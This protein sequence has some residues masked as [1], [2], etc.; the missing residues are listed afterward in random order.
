[1]PQDTVF[2]QAQF[3]SHLDT[4]YKNQIIDDTYPQ[5]PQTKDSSPAPQGE[6]PAADDSANAVLPRVTITN[7]SDSPTDYLNQATDSLRPIAPVAPIPVPH[8]TDA[9]QTTPTKSESVTDIVED[10]QARDLAAQKALLAHP[11]EMRRLFPE[12]SKAFDTDANESLNLNEIN[13]G[14]GQ[15]SLN[16]LQ[17]NYLTVLKNAYGTFHDVPRHGDDPG[18]EKFDMAKI[19]RAMNPKLDEDP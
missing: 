10:R 9:A 18:I 11:E 17:R 5:R 6:T 12:M 4:I 3:K 2:D 1:M 7:R 19:D 8:T 15:H 13:K 16:D 14:L